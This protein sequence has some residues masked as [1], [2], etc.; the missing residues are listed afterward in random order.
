MQIIQCWQAIALKHVGC[1]VEYAICYQAPYG[2]ANKRRLSHQSTWTKLCLNTFKLKFQQQGT[3]WYSDMNATPLTLAYTSLKFR[4]QHL[5]KGTQSLLRSY[6]VEL[7]NEEDLNT[8]DCSSFSQVINFQTVDQTSSQE[9]ISITKLYQK[10]LKCF[11]NQKL[12]LGK[13]KPK[14]FVFSLE[15]V[16]VYYNVLLL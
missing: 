8:Y 7:K 1:P 13:A 5:K 4:S 11:L 15:N 6:K 16:P 3:L 9:V 12:S 14:N 10:T 2:A